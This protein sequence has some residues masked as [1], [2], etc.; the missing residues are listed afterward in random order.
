[1]VFVFLLPILCLLNISVKPTELITAAVF[2]PFFV[3]TARHYRYLVFGPQPILHFLLNSIAVAVLATLVS[4]V[5]GSMAAFAF[6]R[7]PHQRSRGLMFWMVTTRLV[8]PVAFAIPLYVVIR[9]LNLFDTRAAVVLSHS[10]YCVPFVVWIMKNYLD[11]TPAELE[12][13][14]QIDGCS[15]F[16]AFL[17]VT[18]PLAKPGLV[19]AGIL[20]MSISLSEFFFALVLTGTAAKTLPV[21]LVSFLSTHML[22]WGAMAAGAVVLSVPGVIIGLMAQRYLV[23]GLTAGAIK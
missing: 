15:L 2:K 4:L 14:A 7:I 16:G 23:S 17:R 5:A 9:T 1:M 18:L 20:T 3:P 10:I 21:G 22:D 8:P 13:A 6:S 12:E 11:E 19:A